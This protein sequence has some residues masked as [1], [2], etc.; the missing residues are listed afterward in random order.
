MTRAS[1]YRSVHQRDEP[2]RA[3]LANEL[4]LAGAAEARGDMAAAFPHLERAHVLAQAWAWAHV[5]VHWRMLRWAWRARD[6]KEWRGQ[7]L[8]IALAAPSTWLRL[9]PRGNTGGA[10]V[11]VRASL[12]LPT[13]L[14]EILRK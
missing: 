6:A 10:N 4:K 14:A 8:R 12:P 13:D 9:A 11:P 5:A 1:A 2:R 7:C 3:A